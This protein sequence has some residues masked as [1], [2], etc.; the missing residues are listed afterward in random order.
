MR[1]LLHG[2][3]LF[4]VGGETE[5]I[6]GLKKCRDL[7]ASMK[8]PGVKGEKCCFGAAPLKHSKHFTVILSSQ[9][10]CFKLMFSRILISQARGGLR[11]EKLWSKLWSR[12]RENEIVKKK[13]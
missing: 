10:P 13:C 7:F 2:M 6:V 8:N 9:S 5:S 11:L 12:H 4:K 1:T 3:V